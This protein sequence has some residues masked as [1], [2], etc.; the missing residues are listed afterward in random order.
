M[1]LDSKVSYTQFGFD[2]ILEQMTTTFNSKNGTKFKPHELLQYLKRSEIT[3]RKQSYD[4][5]KTKDEI[6]I[7]YI[8]NV[9]SSLEQTFDLQQ[10]L[11][12][13]VMGGAAEILLPYLNVKLDDTAKLASEHPQL[14]NALVYL[15]GGKQYW[16][17]DE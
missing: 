15:D 10:A 16:N 3:L 12:T 1:I 17:V 6:L 13:C 14:T 9:I 2:Q 5:Q 7:D 11:E 4:L 8:D